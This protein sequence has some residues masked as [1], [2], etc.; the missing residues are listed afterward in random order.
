MKVLSISKTSDL[1]KYERSKHLSF[2]MGSFDHVVVILRKCT[3]CFDRGW[4]A[5]LEQSRSLDRAASFVLIMGR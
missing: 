1:P 2:G 5:V 3:S 4:R